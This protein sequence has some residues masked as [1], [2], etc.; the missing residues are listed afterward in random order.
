[1]ILI[2]FQKMEVQLHS[3]LKLLSKL[4]GP[5]DS[6]NIENEPNGTLLDEILKI[7]LKEYQES[8]TLE[9]KTSKS[10]IIDITL[11]QCLINSDKSDT[12]VRWN[13]VVCGLKY[14][15]T[16]NNFLVNIRDVYIKKCAETRD[17][18]AINSLPPDALSIKHQHQLSRLIQLILVLGAIPSFAP[19]VGVPFDKRTKFEIYLRSDPN[20]QGSTNKIEDAEIKY[21]RLVFV[22]ERLMRCLAHDNLSEIIISKHLEDVLAALI[23]LAHRPLMQPNEIQMKVPN[24]SSKPVYLMTQEKF[25]SLQSDQ[26]RFRTT[27][28]NLLNNQNIL[29]P[30]NAIKTLLIL[31]SSGSTEAARSHPLPK[32]INTGQRLRTPKWL[33]NACG[34]LLSSILVNQPKHGV[35][36]VIRG[37]L[38]VLGDAQTPDEG[39]T[40]K[41]QVI[42]N[43]IGNPPKGVEK[44]QDLQLEK[45][46][47]NVC[48]QLLKILS[49]IAQTEDNSGSIMAQHENSNV[50]RIIS[51]ASIQKLNERSSEFSTQHIFN[52]LYLPLVQL[53]KIKYEPNQIVVD[54]GELDKCILQLHFL[55]VI[56]CDPTSSFIELLYPIIPHLLFIHCC[57]C[58]SISSLRSP[59]KELIERYLKHAKIDESIGCIRSF[60]FDCNYLTI[61]NRSQDDAKSVFDLPN[62]CISI[63]LGPSGGL[64]AIWDE[65]SIALDDDIIAAAI[66]DLLNYDMFKDLTL[67]FY[68]FLLEDLANLT[69]EEKS[70]RLLSDANEFESLESVGRVLDLDSTSEIKECSE[71]LSRV[72]IKM[73]RKKFMVIR[74][75]GLMSENEQIRDDPT[76]ILATCLFGIRL[77]ASQCKEQIKKRADRKGS[78]SEHDN[79]IKSANSLN[80]ENLGTSMALLRQCI[81]LNMLQQTMDD[82]SNET[83]WKTMES[84]IPALEYLTENHPERTIQKSSGDLIQIIS[85][86]GAVMKQDQLKETNEK[87]TSTETITKTTNAFDSAMKDIKESE[88]PIRGHGL[89]SLTNLVLKKDSNVMKNF[90]QVIEIFKSGLE[91]DDT[92]LYLQSVKGLAACASVNRHPVI[93][94]LTEEYALLEDSKL[95]EEIVLKKRTKLGEVLVEVTKI[96]GKLTV[97]H[98]N[99]LLNPFLHLLRNNPT[100]HPDPTIRASCLLNIGDICKNI[101]FDITGIVHEI[102]DCLLN[103][104]KSDQNVEVQ[105]AGV[106]ACAMI[107]QGLGVKGCI[108]VLGKEGLLLDLQRTLIAMRDNL[109]TIDDVVRQHIYLALEEI[110]KVAK[111]IFLNNSDSKQM[112]KTIYVLDKP[113]NLF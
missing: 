6:W 84:I 74:L 79:A 40:R 55:F 34:T 102:F 23:Q 69:N 64:V 4:I 112:S 12:D 86:H 20:T 89:I 80:S 1:M 77:S 31:Q 103:I 28:Q 42:A 83:D 92:Y 96:A 88:V 46:Y 87:F 68:K 94:T 63:R 29:Y 54:E 43:V 110:N 78:P 48:P 100:P 90:D 27:L 76:M 56:G 81:S 71:S 62:Q 59:V 105:R 98:K 58:S 19:G 15:D 30:P 57:I 82:E 93:S 11:G 66:A 17:T 13:Y 33:Q 7:K 26:I 67:K 32:S 50:Y 39:D 38:D 3:H 53:T 65:K 49:T 21:H 101:E 95:P 61:H 113:Q 24:K 111:E 109:S 35:S 18:V 9:G 45:Y 22:T 99:S 70:L 2:L 47:S 60:A 5:I 44:S 72:Q 52:P 37:V 51:C 16:L 10:D 91:E 108:Q 85:T 25:E 97:I 14:L 41:Y 73:E 107:L 8:D 36:H 106:L 104:L 75:H